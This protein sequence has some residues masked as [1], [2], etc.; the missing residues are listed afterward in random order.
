MTLQDNKPV[1]ASRRNAMAARNVIRVKLNSSY[2]DGGC[3][4]HA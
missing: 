1:Q 3:Y 2:T 4:R